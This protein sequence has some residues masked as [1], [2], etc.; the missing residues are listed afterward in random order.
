MTTK[1]IKSKIK[2]ALDSIPENLLEDILTYL[3]E[4]QDKSTDQVVLSQRLRRILAEDQGLL[5]KLAQ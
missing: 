1:Q 4:I 2:K 3:K 5:K